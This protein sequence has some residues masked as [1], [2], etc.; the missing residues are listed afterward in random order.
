VRDADRRHVEDRAEV[1]RDAGAAR[2]VPARAVDQEDVR[3]LAQRADRGF[4]EGAF[5]QCEQTRVVRR[6]GATR[7]DCGLTRDESGGPG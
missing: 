3:R 5:A 2:M 4:Q 7:D 1:E 6:A